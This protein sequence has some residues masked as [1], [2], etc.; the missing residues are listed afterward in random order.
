MKKLLLLFVFLLSVSSI[1]AIKYRSV[2]GDA[3]FSVYVFDG[4]YY[5][6]LTFSDNVDNHLTDETIVKFKLT[7]GT[8]LK[9]G[10]FKG[11]SSSSSRSTY[12]GYYDLGQVS[13]NTE[14]KAYS[15]LKITKEQ[16]EQLQ[17]GVDAV[18][19]NT[20]PI[21]YLRNRWSGKDKFGQRLYED[22][23]SLTDEFSSF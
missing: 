19:I 9:M 8:V 15:I 5:L 2:G 14:K 18:V 7:D 22:Y 20:I 4:E 3:N 12:S 23:M 17:K 11:S 1:H 21:A 6:I 13:T 16:I 10:G